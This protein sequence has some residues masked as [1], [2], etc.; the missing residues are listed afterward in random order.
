MIDGLPEKNLP[1]QFHMDNLFSN[2]N[3]FSFLKGCDYRAIGATRENRFPKEC[4][5]TN[6]KYFMKKPRGAYETA[7][8]KNSG[9]LYCRW[10]DNAVVT[11]LSTNTR[12]VGGK[13]VKRY[14]PSEKK[15]L[16]FSPKLLARTTSPWE[17]LTKWTKT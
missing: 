13:T 5:L 8:D 14:C 9:L 6:K 12:A 10:K 16:F 4:P 11:T 2:K 15:R 17:V 3:L 7:L 1:Y